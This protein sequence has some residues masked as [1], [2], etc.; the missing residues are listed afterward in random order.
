MSAPPEREGD[1]R[2]Q[3]FASALTAFVMWGVLPIYWKQLAHV[4]P[5]EVV[6]HR[7]L[8]TAISTNLVLVIAG[9]HREVRAAFST[10]RGLLATVAS[11]LFISLNGLT[12]V[13][14]VAVGRITEVSL[15]YYVNPLLNALLGIVVLRE[16]PTRRQ[17]VAIGLATVGVVYATASQ[18]VFPWVSIVVAACF[19]LYGLVRKVA[20]AEALPGLAAEMTLAAPIGLVFLIVAPPV[21][22]GAFATEGTAT[23]A[24]LMSTGVASALPLYLYTR[25]ARRLAYTTVGVLMYVAPTMQLGV[26]VGVYGEPFTMTHAVTFAFI[27]VAIGLYVSDLGARPR[28]K[29]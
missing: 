9:R 28:A 11:S 8:W 23:T 12:F 10:R 27:W 21:T 20:P 13:W 3:G 17:I 25:G 4:P 19:G 29:A 18:G 16:R 2:R 22:F 6:A 1:E 7:I 5:F 15:G 24:L 26:A 14:A